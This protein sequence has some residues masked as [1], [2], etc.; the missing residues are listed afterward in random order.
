MD[1]QQGVSRSG[2]IEYQVFRS[3]EP[4]APVEGFFFFVTRVKAPAI[5]A[6]EGH[7]WE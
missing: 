1:P 7:S 4:P 3:D 5:A 6:E 2:P